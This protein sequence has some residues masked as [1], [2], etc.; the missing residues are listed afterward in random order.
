[1]SELLADNARVKLQPL[2]RIRRTA[3][4]ALLKTIH[5]LRTYILQNG[6][7]AVMTF[8]F[9]ADLL[10][11]SVALGLPGL[12][13]ISS[14]RDMGMTRSFLQRQVG[15]LAGFRIDRYVAVSKAVKIATMRQEGVAENKILVV[16]NGADLE[17]LLNRKWD[18]DRERRLLGIA[19]EE[20]VIGCVANFNPV[21][22]HHTLIEAFARLQ[23]RLPDHSVRLLLAGDGPARATIEKDIESW[24]LSAKVISVGYSSDPSREYRIA[25]IMVSAS[26]TE[27]F[28]NTIVEAMAF[29]K[30]IVA[31]A[32]GGTPEAIED[33]V[34]GL[35]I[36]P[37]DPARLAKAL[38]R[39]IVDPALCRRLGARA[40][41]DAREKFGRGQMITAIENLIVLATESRKY[42]RQG[43]TLV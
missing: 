39:L 42:D 25:D 18:A 14:R 34:S 10:G 4:L 11:T 38:E 27:G 24:G 8:H 30:P 35:L 2:P 16:H 5:L 29:A 3:S 28:S 20:T 17:G 9:L 40:A 12:T 31:T 15:R 13:V 19:G 6:I 22:G 33:G 37:R 43:V 36:A 26:D 23:N 41:R 32:V 1:M 7:Q 21:K